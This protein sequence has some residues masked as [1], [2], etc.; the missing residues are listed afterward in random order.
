[1]RFSFLFVNPNFLRMVFR[2]KA[3]VSTDT[4]RISAISLFDL[5]SLIKEMMLISF[6]VSPTNVVDK[7][8]KKDEVISNIF[9]SIKV[10]NFD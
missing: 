7:S 8:D 1:M 6:G 9:A 3:T 5:P 10:T 2:W 4:Y